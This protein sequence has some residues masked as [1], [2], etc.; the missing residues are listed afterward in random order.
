[1]SL[2]RTKILVAGVALALSGCGGSAAM[3]P[4]TEPTAVATPVPHASATMAPSAA[5]P[6]SASTL[7]GRILFMRK[8]DDEVTYFSIRPDGSELKEL[9]GADPVLRRTSPD[10]TMF[11]EMFLKDGHFA[12]IF[13]A[14]GSLI[15]TLDLPDPTL[16]LAC[17]T[18]SPDSARLACE[19]W[20]GAK[21]ER[22]GLYTVRADGGDLRHLTSP[23]DHRSDQEAQYGADGSQIRYVHSTD[24]EG[25]LG[26]LWAINVDGTGNHRLISN[27]VGWITAMS[28]DGAL[29]ATKLESDLALYET[30]DFTRPPARL[31]IPD[32]WAWSVAWSPDG[33]HLAFMASVPGRQDNGIGTI[34]R[35]GTGVNILPIASGP[36]HLDLI[37]WLP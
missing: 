30:S 35:D 27:P 7:S 37:G 20:D 17:L 21:P 18:W 16:G 19:G 2:V 25:E 4:A 10:K 6:P 23:A 11:V 5:V 32:S 36:G 34:A 15:R 8:V 31:D 3:T 14:N 26:Q 12:K 28:P 13:A 22:V 1:M 24:E 33:S 9:A 29:L